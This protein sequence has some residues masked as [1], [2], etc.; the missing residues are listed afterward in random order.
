MAKKFLDENFPD[1]IDQCRQYFV[2]TTTDDSVEGVTG[3]AHIIYFK[4]FLN[5]DLIIRDVRKN[6]QSFF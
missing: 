2:D 5:Y 6:L 3:N 1:E 4:P